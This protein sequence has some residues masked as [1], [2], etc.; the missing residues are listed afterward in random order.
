M[1][2]T[3]TEL[4][5][6][7]C[8]EAVI[9]SN[10]INYTDL[11]TRMT[12]SFNTDQD[13]IL[14]SQEYKFTEAFYTFT[15]VADQENYDFAVNH[16][17][18]K[19]VV[20]VIDSRPHEPLI[21]IVSPDEWDILKADSVGYTTDFPTHFHVRN[22]QIYIY[23]TPGSTDVSFRILYTKRA[24]PMRYTDYLTGSIAVT[25]GSK[26]V[27]GTG[28]TWNSTVATAG[29]KIRIKDDWYEVA[30]VTGTTGI[31]LTQNYQGTTASGITDYVIGDTP[32]LHEDFQLILP[33]KFLE[34]YF[35]RND[36]KRANNYKAEWMRLKIGMDQYVVSQTTSRV[37]DLDKRAGINDPYKTP[38][39]LVFSS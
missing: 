3:L 20:P 34:R 27:V 19:T 13:E 11:R 1:I 32:L 38:R 28:T 6:F 36:P 15:A 12:K 10:D 17:K 9:E 23:P 4:L 24:K 8:F 37:I 5:D 18:I 29:T 2:Q 21:E 33:Y 22:K 39:N 14:S 30:T 26:S 7:T 35:R 31:T 16:K 25:N